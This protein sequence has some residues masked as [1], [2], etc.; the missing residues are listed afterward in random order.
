[1]T[2]NSK[3]LFQKS[4]YN[5]YDRIDNYLPIEFMN[6]DSEMV[7]RYTFSEPSK[8]I[9]LDDLVDKN[10]SFY[11][12]NNNTK[13]IDKVFHFNKI[14]NLFVDVTGEKHNINTKSGFMT[15]T[16]CHIVLELLNDCRLSSINFEINLVNDGKVRINGL[17]TPCPKLYDK[18]LN[19][20]DK[21]DDKNVFKGFLVEKR[22]EDINYYR[23]VLDETNIGVE[24]DILLSQFNYG[25][26]PEADLK[27]KFEERLLQAKQTSVKKPFCIP[28]GYENFEKKL[29]FN[30]EIVLEN[31]FSFYHHSEDD[32]VKFAIE[33]RENGKLHIDSMSKL[34]LDEYP[35]PN[36]SGRIFMVSTNGQHRRLVFVCLGL[37]KIEAKIQFVKCKSRNWKYYFY[38][39]NRPMEK[40]IEWL[41]SKGRIEK[42][43]CLDGR[44]VLIEDN[45]Q[46]IPWI[47]PNSTISRFS[48]IR[49]DMLERLQFVE[50]SFGSQDFKYG[51]IRKSGVLW[52][53]DVQ[54][55]H[56]INIFRNLFSKV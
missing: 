41:I 25:D 19:D 51:F 1:M 36:V 23:S 22:Q 54:R 10:F 46:L 31:G 26:C 9:G 8:I 55:V 2:S 47:L 50:K 34:Y 38:K 33:N 48:K 39:K 56:L 32:I 18:L 14:E 43:E 11:N 28:N 20:K 45:T 17:L 52:Y 5:V 21:D 44:T 49:K 13:V 15:A 7:M 40:V 3:I 24:K 37:K 42:I 6:K 30:D 35:A 12:K 4:K 16:F 29:V 27:I 53:L